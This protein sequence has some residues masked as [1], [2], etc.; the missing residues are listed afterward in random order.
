MSSSPCF[1]LLDLF[2]FAVLCAIACASRVWLSLLWLAGPAR[3]L[4]GT[5]PWRNRDHETRRLLYRYCPKHVNFHGGTFQFECVRIPL[6][7]ECVWWH[8]CATA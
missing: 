5:L 4:H 6:F 1:L 8:N 2:V 3:T 7:F